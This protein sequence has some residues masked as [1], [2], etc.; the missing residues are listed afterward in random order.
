MDQIKSRLEVLEEQN[1]LLK[2][3]VTIL[4]DI[5][6]IQKVERAYG[7]YLEHMLYDEVTD[8]WADNGAELEWMG[9]GV[10]KGKGEIRKAWKTL[11]DSEPPEFIHMSIQVSP[12]I[13]LAPD[14]KTATGRWYCIGIATTQGLYENEYIKEEGIWKI[15]RLQY[16]AFPLAKTLGPPQEPIDESSGQLPP[17]PEDN[18]P[19]PAVLERI[20]QQHFS[21]YQFTARLDRRLRQEWAPYIRPFSF[22]HPV[23]GKDSANTTVAA[24]N[25]KHP[26]QMPPGGEKWIKGDKS[27]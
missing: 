22:K 15:K 4:E 23:T 12:Y 21:R 9:L 3:R 7:Y 25:A 1:E 8:L 18:G 16:G 27:T 10:F 19:D 24:W 5:E 14:G 17:P 6:A 2:K 20:G 13:Q 11:R 26:A